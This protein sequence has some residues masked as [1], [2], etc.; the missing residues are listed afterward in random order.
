[1]MTP[2][3]ALGMAATELARKLEGENKKFREFIETWQYEGQLQ[4]FESREIF[5]KEAKELLCV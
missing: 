2:H 4:T 1:M 3:D 5:R